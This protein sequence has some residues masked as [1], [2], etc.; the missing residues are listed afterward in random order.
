MFSDRLVNKLAAKGVRGRILQVL[1]SWLEKRY[2]VVVV[3][4]QYSTN[5]TLQNMVYQGTVLGPP[6]WNTYFED[7]RTAVN[8]SGFEDAFFA[9][10]LTCDRLYDK[11]LR[12][13][14]VLDE[15]SEC[16]SVLHT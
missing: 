8:Q 11:T 14:A 2:A 15:L 13:E 5:K 1:K 7:S 3:D 6:L 4:G 16:Q 12:N 10:D 9:D